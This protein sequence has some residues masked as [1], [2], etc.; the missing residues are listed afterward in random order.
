MSCQ[1]VSTVPGMYVMYSTIIQPSKQNRF[2]PISHH[3]SIYCF[4]AEASQSAR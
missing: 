1:V 2:N 3:L 4:P